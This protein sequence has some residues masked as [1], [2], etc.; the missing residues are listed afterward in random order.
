MPSAQ[1]P[2]TSMAT[3]VTSVRSQRS[4]HQTDI[5]ATSAI[6]KTLSLALTISET[7]GA[8]E[9]VGTS[10]GDGCEKTHD[11][12]PM[13]WSVA[14]CPRRRPKPGPRLTG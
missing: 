7:A 12:P 10:G 8:M 14:P 6:R 13:G 9:E 1:A 3:E 5:A 4:A 2:L 11:F